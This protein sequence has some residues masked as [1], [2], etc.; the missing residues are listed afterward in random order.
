M[1]IFLQMLEVRKV[2][3]GLYCQ[4]EKEQNK[5]LGI[6]RWEISENMNDNIKW[7]F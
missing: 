6:N 5:T 2:K 7:Q 4:C 3:E 1:Y